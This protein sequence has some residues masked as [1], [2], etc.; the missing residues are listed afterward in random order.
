MLNQVRV[1]VNLTGRVFVILTGPGMLNQVQ[2]A[3]SKRMHEISFKRA[4]SRGGVRLP[5]RSDQ[6]SKS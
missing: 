5:K 1:F 4:G 3:A 6:V 2:V